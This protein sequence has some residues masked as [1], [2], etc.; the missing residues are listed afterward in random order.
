L[1]DRL[2]RAGMATAAEYAWNVRIDA[3]E[4]FLLQVAE[5]R[6]LASSTEAVPQARR[7]LAR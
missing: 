4:R 7:A 1:R 2:G 6:T 5:P 3:L